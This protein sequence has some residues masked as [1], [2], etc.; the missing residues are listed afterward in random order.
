MIEVDLVIPAW[1]LLRPTIACA[2]SYRPHFRWQ[3]ALDKQQASPCH[4]LQRLCN[5]KIY[6]QFDVAVASDR[7]VS[8][9]G[10]GDSLS[11]CRRTCAC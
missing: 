1:Q 10:M 5:K 8:M 6:R 7:G 9:S 2:N 3:P 11:V 4:L